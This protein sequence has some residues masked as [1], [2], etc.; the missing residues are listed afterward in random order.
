M[1]R[2]RHLK[3]LKSSAIPI[4]RKPHPTPI[5]LPGQSQIITE[6]LQKIKN[7]RFPHLCRSAFDSAVLFQNSEEATASEKSAVDET[8]AKPD[9]AATAASTA[10]AETPAAST[11]ASADPLKKRGRAG[12]AK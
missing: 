10:A 2:R 11:T 9:T 6:V 12:R 8:A 3:F 5:A 7:N 4:L 1:Y